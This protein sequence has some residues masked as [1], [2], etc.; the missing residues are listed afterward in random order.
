[1]TILFNFKA[2]L[3]VAFAFA[4]VCGLEKLGVHASN[5]LGLVV[6]VLLDLG[7]RHRNRKARPMPLAYVH[8]RTG[9]HLFFIPVWLAG[10]AGLAVATFG[11]LT[12]D[13]RQARLDADNTVL[14]AT[15][16]GGSGYSAVLLDVLNQ[17]LDQKTGIKDAHVFSKVEDDR[18]LVLV[19]IPELKKF[20]PAARGQL[21]GLIKS[22]TDASFPSKKAY[23]GLRGAFAYGATRA[24]DKEDIDTVADESLLFDFYGPKSK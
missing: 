24:G 4:V 3:M 11:A 9:G 17:V 2:L 21:L 7:V 15:K 10:C 13:P 6:L 8:P 12:A 19:Q 20:A 23:I 16:A 22:T 14:L 18:V 1:M 5:V